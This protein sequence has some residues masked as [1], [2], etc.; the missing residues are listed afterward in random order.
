MSHLMKQRM[1]V[2]GMGYVG[3]PL[4]LLAAS[5]GHSVS[6]FDID[7]KKIEFLER[8][9]SPLRDEEL[10]RSLSQLHAN[11]GF[12]TSE[13]M[14]HHADVII[15]CVPTPVDKDHKP[16]LAPLRSASESV[17]RHLRSGQLVVVE[18]TIFPG[19]ME[20]I[21]LPI[22]Q[23]TGLSCG[24]EYHLAHCPERVDPG[25]KKYPLPSIPRLI[26]GITKACAE[27]A[28]DFYSTIIEAPITI[29]HSIKAVETSKI[30]ENT[31]RDV[32]IALVNELAKAFDLMGID[33]LEVIKGA[34]TKPFAFMPHYPGCGVGGHCIAVDP[35]YLIEKS[36]EKGFE[37]KFLSLARTINRE[38]PAYTVQ[39]ARA[40][41]QEAGLD[42]TRA[43]VAVLGLA[44]K[45]EIDD[46][47]ES[48]AFEVIK[49]V[50]KWGVEPV[51][52][53]P[54]IPQESTSKNLREALQN[55]DCVIV[56]TD[57]SEFKNLSPQLLK[58]NNVK[59]VV[60]GRNCLD[61]EGIQAAGIIYKGIGR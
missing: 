53:D 13:E 58:E 42:A 35:Y 10:Q 32:N 19:T 38:M 20:E 11:M 12:S 26:G 8:G 40:G 54:Y 15:I 30:V 25:N 52:Y 44:Y 60:D 1:S 16:D 41:L 56:A 59:V 21:V 24:K 50:Q 61:K 45:K 2:I 33:V 4:A 36:R 18:S 23:R 29:L 7:A 57:H 17:A 9:I 34:S 28:K 46:T 22:L 49:E 6:G 5:K 14:L 39:R 48:P 43:R 47:R 37:H 55:K 3:I 31:F 51:V 27:R